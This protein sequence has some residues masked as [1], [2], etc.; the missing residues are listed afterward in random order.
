VGAGQRLDAHS[1]LIR[2]P[3]APTRP[4]SGRTSPPYRSGS[5]LGG[6]DRL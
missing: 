4:R 1:L 3:G 2:E 6:G 5:Q